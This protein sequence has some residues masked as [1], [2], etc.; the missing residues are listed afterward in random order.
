M[1][2]RRRTTRNVPKKKRSSSKKRNYRRTSNKSLKEKFLTTAIWGVSLINIALL[3]SL[4]SNFFA[5]SGETTTNTTP[6]LPNDKITVEVLNACGVPGLANQLTEYLRA[7]KFDVVEVGNYSGG[8]NLDR[9][10]VLD[11]VSLKTVNAKKVGDALGVDNEQ[12]VPQL[13][14]SLQLMV[15]VLI[16][17]DYQELKIFKE[18]TQ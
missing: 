7:K 10:F 5:T 14:D 4:F 1:V 15:T 2:K 3:V 16:G 13:D 17:K 18:A 8:F 6:A 12:V 9:T 11:R